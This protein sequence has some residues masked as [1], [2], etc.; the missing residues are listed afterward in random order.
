MV[1]L[2]LLPPSHLQVLLMPNR[3]M[4]SSTR[5]QQLQQQPSHKELLEALFQAG[6]AALNSAKRRTGAG[7]LAVV[8]SKQG[9]TTVTDL[10]DANETKKVNAAWNPL[11]AYFGRKPDVNNLYFHLHGVLFVMVPHVAAGSP[12]EVE[13]TLCS[14]NDITRPTLQSKSFRL[15]EGPQ[16]VIMSADHCL[17]LLD[18]SCNFFYTTRTMDTT[19]KVPCSVMAIW[20]QEISA[21]A[22]S[23]NP[24]EVHAWFIKKLSMPEFLR[25]KHQAAS[26]LSTVYGTG[27]SRVS[28]GT[29]SLI[30]SSMRVASLDAGPSLERSSSVHPSLRFLPA[31]V[32]L[33]SEPSS[34][35]ASDDHPLAEKEVVAHRD[36]A[37]ARRHQGI[38]QL[39]DHLASFLS[40]TPQGPTGSYD[41]TEHE[42]ALCFYN[43]GPPLNF[44]SIVKFDNMLREVYFGGRPIPMHPFF[45]QGIS[46]MLFFLKP[47]LMVE[48]KKVLVKHLYRSTKGLSA[49]PSVF[50]LHRSLALSLAQ[51][52]SRKP[53][54]HLSFEEPQTDLVHPILDFVASFERGDELS[55]CKSHLNLSGQELEAVERLHHARA[56]HQVG[57]DLFHECY[58][59][60]FDEWVMSSHDKCKLLIAQGPGGG[61]GECSAP[62]EGG[63]GAHNIVEDLIVTKQSHDSDTFF[64]C[65]NDLQASSNPAAP[66]FLL[67]DSEASNDIF[68]FSSD[69]SVEQMQCVELQQPAI[70]SSN[71]KF[72][73]ESKTF[74]WNTTDTD[75]TNLLKV[76]IPGVLSQTSNVNAVGPNLLRYFDAAVLRFGAF[77]T[78]PRT[79]SSTG[80]L[81]LIWDE[82]SLVSAYGKNVNKAT[83][84]ACPHVIVS[85]HSAERCSPQKFLYFVPLGIGSFVPLDLG[86]AG[87]HIGTLSVYVLNQLKT[88]SVITKFTCTVQIYVTVL[89]TNIMQPQRVLA[90]SQLGMSPSKTTFP[91]L[92]LKQLIV[93]T[94]W[95]TTHEAGSGALVTFSPVGVFESLGVLQPSLMCNLAINCHWWRGVCNFIVRFN[96]TAFHSGR[97]AIGFGTLNTQLSQHQDIFSLPH[98]VL[99]LNQ[100]EIFKFSVSMRNWNGVNLLSAGRKNSLPR[101]DHQSLQRIFISILEPLQCTQ[102]GLSAVTMM[103]F[104]DSISGCE[105]GGV[106]PIKPVMGHNSKGSSGVDFLFHEA[107]I[108]SPALA[109]MRMSTPKQTQDDDQSKYKLQPQAP[110]VPTRSKF[111]FWS[112]QYTISP[113]ATK[114]TLVIPATCWLYNFPK[115]S[116]ILTSPVSPMTGF[117]N[118]FVY[119]KGS[120]EFKIIVHRRTTTSTC[121][122]VMSV[123]FESTGYPKEPGLYAATMP[124]SNGGGLQWGEQYGIVSNEV[125][126]TIE[127]D[128][129]FQRRFTRQFAMG[130]GAS[131]I[132]TL[133]DKL[134]LLI[135]VLPDRDFY[136]QIEIYVKPGRDFSFIRPHPPVPVATAVFGEMEGNVYSLLPKEGKF[137]PIED[138]ASIL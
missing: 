129:F 128:E 21:K 24:Q 55:F 71:Q 14:T 111:S 119:W 124:I 84:C 88:M 113:Q 30:S 10:F 92:P 98:V 3:M 52:G 65:G 47:S 7:C 80:D 11:K 94:D 48:M 26:L 77:V 13:I 79:L 46:D 83:L 8:R 96:K 33:S 25:D 126:F 72:L 90:Q 57:D 121:G 28:S 41:I 22:G 135:I 136:N 45:P 50:E 114:R 87:S 40:P 17:P 18:D 32:P 123:A 9:E 107:D 76:S 42:F 66:S 86:H 78:V 134:G 74:S 85:A 2:F 93:S 130:A 70:V 125:T 60:S 12:G 102:G 137:V 23:Y 59:E 104:L 117:T 19:A 61:E 31:Q 99:D 132:S 138:Q 64:E 91:L 49:L 36:Q 131:R 122:G 101:P 16:A 75:S 6:D 112:L 68:D 108:L 118:A 81:I 120:L 15:G 103:L 115:E 20:K 67:D 4:T 127:D 89:S 44:T 109:A 58:E 133:S 39:E 105:L 73:V 110:M 37:L 1:L 53:F 100:G 97:V 35:R 62:M 34:S 43:H 116:G 95:D 54:W 27:S 106:V 29:N 56:L 38:N 69:Y 51:G 5:G 82:G 63:E